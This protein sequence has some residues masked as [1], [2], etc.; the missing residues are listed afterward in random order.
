[1]LKFKNELGISNDG[2]IIGN[3][4][5]KSIYQ[6]DNDIYNFHEEKL[7]STFGMKLLD[8]S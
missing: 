6:K 2:N 1:M 8:I 5:Y 4:V 3:T 7:S